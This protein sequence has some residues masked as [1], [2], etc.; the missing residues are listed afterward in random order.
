M[1]DSQSWPAALISSC[2]CNASIGLS[3]NTTI[4]GPLPVIIVGY[5]RLVKNSLQMT[6]SSWSGKSSSS[7]VLALVRNADFK[8]LFSKCC[9]TVS[10]VCF[11]A[12]DL[13]VS[14][15]KQLQLIQK[16]LALLVITNVDLEISVR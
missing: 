6:S 10:M 7:N 13:F 1:S 11:V 4:V 5:P 9:W 14:D 15:H 8:S 16:P 3:S 2:S 12:T